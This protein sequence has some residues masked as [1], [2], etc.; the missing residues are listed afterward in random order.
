[1]K[2]TSEEALETSLSEYDWTALFLLAI[3]AGVLFSFAATLRER[4]G[5][6]GQLC[7]QAEGTPDVLP[8]R[9][10]A[11][12][13]VTGALGFFAVLG[14]RALCRARERGDPAALRRAQANALA[15]ALV[16]AAALVRLDD[17]AFASAG[18]GRA[19]AE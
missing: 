17:L 8:L 11:G 1:M 10:P 16:F 18:R 13:L 14:R 5:L 3:I 4:S 2:E 6:I 7:G 15:G 12:A 9:W 19:Q